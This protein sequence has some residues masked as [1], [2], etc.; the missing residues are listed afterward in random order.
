MQELRCLGELS[1]IILIAYH[2]AFFWKF[3]KN[4]YLLNTSE[5]ASNFY[6][7]WKWSGI[8]KWPVWKDNIYYLY[9][10]SIPFLSCFYIPSVVFLKINTAFR[11]YAYLILLHYLLGSFLA[12][13][14]LKQYFS[15]WVALFG[16]IS[17]VYNAYNIRLQTPCFSFT[18]CWLMGVLHPDIGWFCLGMA[19]LGGYWPIVLTAS[20]ILLLNPS[21]LWGVLIG[22]PQII[23]FLW[24]FPKSIRAKK[25]YDKNW[26]RMPIWRYFFR[27]TIPENGMIHYPEY[28]FGVGI[29]AVLCIFSCIFVNIS[30]YNHIWL[31]IAMVGFI[32]SQG[33]LHF[34][35][36]PARWVYLVSYSLICGAC[37][38]LGGVIGGGGAI[39][40]LL[41]IQ[42]AFLW[43]N[44]TIYPSFPFSQWWRK[45]HKFE[46]T[47]WPNNTGYWN[48]VGHQNYYGG[49]SLAEN[50]RE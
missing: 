4:P 50:F 36:I 25:R 34:D 41:V 40:P 46:G 35:R 27:S 39:L 47:D 5:V 18:S 10:A 44:R 31:L 7:F 3:Y 22:L 29:C 20:P 48:G 43:K 23:P 16:A 11:V 13:M 26:G 12:F 14:A 42:M 15:E 9:P 32:G 19:L 2:F 45:E 21:C 33:Y 38:A 30:V 37:V 17:L 8:Q 6:P 24:Y 49:F 1:A 28:S